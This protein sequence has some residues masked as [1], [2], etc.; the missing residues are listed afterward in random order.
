MGRDAKHANGI[1]NRGSGLNQ[2]GKVTLSA[3]GVGLSEHSIWVSYFVLKSSP[4]KIFVRWRVMT[5]LWYMEAFVPVM[6]RKFAIH[7]QTAN[8]DDW[9]TPEKRHWKLFDKPNDNI[10]NRGRETSFP[11]HYVL[12]GISFRKVY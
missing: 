5:R 9:S 4:Y 3:I 2:K 1:A 6:I 11:K 7:D 12:L 8:P 10:R